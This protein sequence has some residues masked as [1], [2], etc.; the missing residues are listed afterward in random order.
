MCTIS[1]GVDAL[2]S[3]FDSAPGGAVSL[4]EAVLCFVVGFTVLCIINAYYIIYYIVLYCIYYSAPYGAVSLRD[5]VLCFVVGFTA[6]YILY[7]II[8]YFLYYIIY[9]MRYHSVLGGAVSLV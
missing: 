7:Y 2:G 3:V 5:A 9:K 1:I 4:V 6:S 8:L